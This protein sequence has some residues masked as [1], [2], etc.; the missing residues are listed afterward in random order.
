MYGD[1]LV[2]KDVCAFVEVLDEEIFA[3]VLC[4]FVVVNAALR[5]GAADYV[6]RFKT[7]RPHVFEVY[8][9]E[10]A[11]GADD[12]SCSYLVAGAHL[13]IGRYL[14]EHGVAG[15]V[16]D[17]E[18]HLFFDLEL[19][20]GGYHLVQFFKVLT[21]H[22]AV[23]DVVVGVFDGDFSHLL[24]H[25]VSLPGL[26]E[27]ARASLGVF[28]VGGNATYD[29]LAERFVGFDF[30]AAEKHCVACLGSCLGGAPTV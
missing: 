19:V 22:R 8:V 14:A 17:I 11:V 3:C 16:L 5:F 1:E 4:G 26:L 13:G 10:V 23:A 7:C 20:V 30:V 28:G 29:Y 18:V 15:F 21:V 12:E 9:V 24:V 2:L 25:L 6:E 27:I